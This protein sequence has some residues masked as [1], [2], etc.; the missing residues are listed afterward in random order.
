MRDILIKL[1]DQKQVYGID[2]EQ[3]RNHD[4]L[5]LDNDE[6]A[7]HLLANGVTVN[8]WIP[9]AERLPKI[10]VPV[11]VTY[12]NAIDGT[13][14][15]DGV[16]VQL[17]GENCWYWW[18]GSVEDC[19]WEVRVEITHWMP[20]PEPPSDED[21]ERETSE[22]YGEW[23]DSH[24]PGSVLSECSLCHY[25]CGAYTMKFCP[26]CGHP[27]KRNGGTKQSVSEDRE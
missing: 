2:N 4:L 22:V 13:P 24:V 14:Q 27:M 9:V 26:M 19:D 21:A 20:L 11:L 10:G 1:I 18:E 8:R 16:A 17:F 15:G 23:I 7:D 5:L 25:D 6:L 12:F 3:Q